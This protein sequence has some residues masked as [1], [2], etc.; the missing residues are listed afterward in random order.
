M[1]PRSDQLERSSARALAVVLWAAAAAIV[2]AGMWHIAAQVS[3]RARFAPSL[4]SDVLYG[5]IGDFLMVVRYVALAC[6]LVA[7]GRAVMLAYE[8]IVCLRTL[9]QEERQYPYLRLAAAPLAVWR[10]VLWIYR[11]LL[12]FRNPGESEE[13]EE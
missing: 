6:A 3:M 2:V 1:K 11:T 5:Y 12:R 7:G 13:E 10:A 9:A 4:T 8:G